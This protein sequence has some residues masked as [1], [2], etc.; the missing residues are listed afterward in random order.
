MLKI[1]EAF[2]RRVDPN[3]PIKF[4]KNDFE[5]V[6]YVVLYVDGDD[7]ESIETSGRGIVEVLKQLMIELKSHVNTNIKGLR[8]SE[9]N[10]WLEFND[11]DDNMIYRCDLPT[12][13]TDSNGNV[14]IEKTPR[15][16]LNNVDKLSLG[17]FDRYCLV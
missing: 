7:I 16:G 3:K 9:L 8:N 17:M 10:P 13:Y 1:N 14:M 11:I 6:D 12:M 15:I 2:V 4:N 5:S